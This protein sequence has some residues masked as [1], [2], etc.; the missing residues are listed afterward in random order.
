ME[1]III[2]GASGHAKVV[3]DIIEKN[4]KYEIFGFIDTYKQI[5]TKILGYQIIGNETQI[6]YLMKKEDIKQGIIAIGD[7]WVRKQ[8]FMKIRTIAPDFDFISAIHPS[9]RISNSAIIKKGTVIMAGAIVNSDSKIGIFSIVNSMS[10]LG[11]DGNMLDFS[12]LSSGVVIG[13][14]VTIGK[15]T[16]ISIGATIIN[17]ISIGKHTVVG[18]GA[19]ATKDIGD[20]EIAYGVPAKFIKKRSKGDCYLCTKK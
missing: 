18:A 8:M 4:G 12:S 11:H 16:A 10:S 6:P 9:A 3:A 2:I 13:G 5:G 7:N 20:F 15:Y 14:N 1:K 17:N 19:V